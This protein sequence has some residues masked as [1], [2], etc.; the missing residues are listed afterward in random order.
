[1]ENEKN[2]NTTDPAI[3]IKVQVPEIKKTMRDLHSTPEQ[4]SK[5]KDTTS[6][7]ISAKHL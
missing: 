4:N 2:M 3:R 7:G 1:M 6:A 5:I